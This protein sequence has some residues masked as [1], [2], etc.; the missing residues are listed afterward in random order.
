MPPTLQNDFMQRGFQPP[1]LRELAAVIFRQQRIFLT[2]AGLLGVATV[3]YALFGN[4][5]QAHMKVLVGRGRVDA[6][7]TAQ[8]NAPVDLARMVITEEELNSEVELLKDD[9]VLRKVAATTDLANHDWLGFLRPQE[10]RDQKME[11]AVRRLAKKIEVEPVKKTNLINVSYGSSDPARAAKVLQTLA[12]VYWEKHTEVHRPTGEFRFF[13]QQSGESRRQLEEAQEK[14]RQFM[15]RHDVVA[16]AQQRDLALQRLS[17]VDAIY[18]QTQI[19]LAETQRRVKE[20]QGQV[21]ILPQRT[22]T[23]MRTADNPDLLRALKTSLLELELKRTDLLTKFEPSHPLVQE[24]ERQIAQAKSAVAAETVNPLRD[25]TTDKDPNYEWAKAELQRAEVNLRALQEKAVATAMQ[26]SS[27]RTLSLQ[28]GEDAITQDDLLSTEKAA[29]ESYLLYVQKRE[30]AR[31]NDALDERGIVNVAIA[32]RP[33]SPAL[34]R[35]SA[36]AILTVG[37]VAAGACGTGAAFAADYLDS[38]FRT[39]DEVLAFLQAPVLASL[40][41]KTKHGRL[42]QWRSVS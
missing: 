11:R 2:V 8:Q 26:L 33:M 23:Q 13:E 35:W 12:D 21:Q 7:V 37:F 1:T 38:A 4:Q 25:E 17:D 27:Y 41:A 6:P 16:A 32:E 19:E 14:L 10:T 24:V 20:L 42:V 29:R 34:P 30:E 40:P 39:P 22:T 18:R 36:W 28:M 3:L 15:L 9:E 5:Y 31:L